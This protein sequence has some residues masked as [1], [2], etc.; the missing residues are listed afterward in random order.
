MEVDNDERD[1]DVEDL[2]DDV[3]AVDDGGDG[4]GDEG[5][6]TDSERLIDGNGPNSACCSWVR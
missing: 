3:L 6:V 4:D 2:V 1:D 5:G